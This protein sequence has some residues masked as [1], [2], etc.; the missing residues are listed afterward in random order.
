MDIC[1]CIMDI[2]VNLYYV[3]WMFVFVEASLSEPHIDLL[4]QQTN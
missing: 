3:L 4:L 2:C 1:I